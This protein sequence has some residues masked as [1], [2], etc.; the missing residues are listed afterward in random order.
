MSRPLLARRIALLASVFGATALTGCP[1]NPER[2]AI[3]PGVPTAELDTDPVDIVEVEEAPPVVEPA[4]P[5]LAD[6]DSVPPAEEGPPVTGS[7]AGGGD[8]PPAVL[9]ER[10]RDF[11]RPTLPDAALRNEPEEE[12]A[13]PPETVTDRSAE[14]KDPMVLPGG[15]PVGD[16]FEGLEEK[17][18]G[19]PNG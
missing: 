14:A 13:D 18:S 15:M 7:V 19:D 5:P 11:L 4:E 10:P 16:L 2:P 12:P 17:P 9:L 1:A 6:G 3:D 8:V